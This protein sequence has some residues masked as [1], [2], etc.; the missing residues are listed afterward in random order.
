MS[1]HL[2]EGH[3][4]TAHH[5]ILADGWWLGYLLVGNPTDR[6]EQLGVLAP[7]TRQAAVTLP[8]ACLQG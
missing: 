4:P 7:A 5:C 2:G 6:Q 1:F 3:L 8:G